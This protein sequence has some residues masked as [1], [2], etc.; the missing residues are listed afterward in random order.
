MAC[1]EALRNAKKARD[2]AAIMKL[3]TKYPQFKGDCYDTLMVIT[4]DPDKKMKYFEIVLAEYS[5]PDVKSCK[6]GKRDM[7]AKLAKMPLL[8]K[9]IET[10]QQNK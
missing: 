3:I 8:K 1:N 10:L 5:K 9:Q 4:D 2:A 7:K 6:Y